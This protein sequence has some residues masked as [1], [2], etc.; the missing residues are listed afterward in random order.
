MRFLFGMIVGIALTICGAYLLD[1]GKDATSTETAA[2]PMVNWDV[3]DITWQRASTRVRHE[4]NKLAA[5]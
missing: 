1:S 4:W 2:R 5:K 3:V